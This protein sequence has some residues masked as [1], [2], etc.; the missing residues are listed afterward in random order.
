MD[1]VIE[2]LYEKMREKNTQEES[3]TQRFFYFG[4]EYEFE[5]KLRFVGKVKHEDKGEQ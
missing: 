1:T 5:G 3:M 4:S 2:N